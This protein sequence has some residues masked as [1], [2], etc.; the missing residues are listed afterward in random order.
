M[1]ALL[2]IGIPVGCTL[3]P[4]MLGNSGQFNAE[5]QAWNNACSDS[6]F[7]SMFQIQYLAKFGNPY[8]MNIYARDVI[9]TYHYLGLLPTSSN[10]G[11]VDITLSTPDYILFPSTN[12]VDAASK[13]GQSMFTL[14]T[15]DFTLPVSQFIATLEINST[16]QTGTHSILGKC[17]TSPNAQ[18]ATLYTCVN[19]YLQAGAGVVSGP[20]GANPFLRD[21]GN[22]TLEIMY[23]I[24]PAETNSTNSTML[25]GYIGSWPSDTTTFMPNNVP[26]D[27]PPSGVLREDDS[28]G[29][30]LEMKDVQ[31]INSPW[32]G[33]QGLIVCATSG[34][35]GMIAAGWIW[36]NLEKWMWY[37]SE[38]CY[39]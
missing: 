13:A 36:E 29:N 19:G 4:F 12:P 16:A 7:N 18:N 25:H 20:I 22:Q 8:M 38:D 30:I 28:L 21:G 1:F 24:L 32:P 39:N 17:T 33:C 9:G 27:N 15:N 23:D 2:L 31:V 37:S 14:L 11:N 5:T 35:D 26:L 3:I 6:K 10:P 34:L